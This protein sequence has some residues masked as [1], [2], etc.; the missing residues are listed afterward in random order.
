[1]QPDNNSAQPV[2]DTKYS[3]LTGNEMYCGY[4]LGFMPG[5]LIGWK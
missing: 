2:S 5:K 4:L 1:M 3:G